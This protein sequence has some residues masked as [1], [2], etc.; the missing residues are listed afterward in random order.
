MK[1]LFIFII[2]SSTVLLNAKIWVREYTYNASEAD[3]KITS[4]SIALEQVKRL[5]LQ[6]IGVYVHSTVL[7]GEYEASGEVKDLSAKQIEIISAGITETK[8]IEENWNGETYYI[9]AEITADENDVIN[10]LDKIIEDKEKTKQLED[11][12]QRTEEALIEIDRLKQQLT[13]TKDDNEKLVLQT[14]Y[15][16]SSNEL[17]AEDW[18][19]KGN[20][21][22]EIGDYENAFLFFQK[23]LDIEPD[24]EVIYNN[25]GIIYKKKGNYIKA[26]ECYQRA[27]EINPDDETSYYNMGNI[28]IEKNKYDKAIEYYKK[29]IEINPLSASTN[30]NMGIAYYDKDNFDIT[31][32][33]FQKAIE[34]NPRDADTYYNLGLVYGNKDNYDKAIEYFKKAIE[35]EPDYAESYYSMGHVYRKKNNYTKTIECWQKALEINPDYSEAYRNMGVAYQNKGNYEKAI[36][37]YQKVLE[38][39]PDDANAYYSMGLTYTEK[40]N[41]EKAIDCFH[42]VIEINP[43]YANAYYSMGI[44]YRDGETYREDEKYGNFFKCIKKAAQ[45]GDKDAQEF[46]KDFEDIIDE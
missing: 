35:I 14:K 23:A 16:K 1:K 36:E 29:A 45:L 7:S 11:S 31:I 22:Y 42:K 9:K 19:Q 33:C 13:Q 15:N 32:N 41:Y 8:I 44:A 39:N 25:M 30:Y 43:E 20:Y 12:H 26:I 34:I 40:E 6:E 3:S 28:Y 21:A 5:L 38:I 17:S 37:C 4:R 27:I 18:F 10:R 46:L 24:Q 2:L